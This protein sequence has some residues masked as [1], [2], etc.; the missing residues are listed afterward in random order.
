MS[1]II[2]YNRLRVTFHDVIL[3]FDVAQ[4]YQYKNPRSHTGI[5]LPAPTSEL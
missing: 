4:I 5:W 3:L 2:S 1:Q